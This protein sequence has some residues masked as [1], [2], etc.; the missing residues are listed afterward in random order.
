MI[1][2]KNPLRRT[3]PKGGGAARIILCAALAACFLAACRTRPSIAPDEDVHPPD[4][5]EYIPA[6]R[7]FDHRPYE[8]I[9]AERRLDKDQTSDFE[10]LLGWTVRT[11]EGVQ[12]AFGRSQDTQLWD[13]YVGAVLY[14]TAH[15]GGWAVLVPPEP[16]QIRDPVDTATLWLYGAKELSDGKSGPTVA[17]LLE[18]VSGDEEQLE[19]GVID[20]QGWRK[21]YRRLP[22]KWTDPALYPIALKSIH[23]DAL[24]PAKDRTI[25]MD[26][27]CL[28]METL[29]HLRYPVRP[30]RPLTL[31][32]GQLIGINTGEGALHFPTNEWTVIPPPGMEEGRLAIERREDG[33]Y[34]LALRNDQ[35]GP[36]YRVDVS[37][38]VSLVQ[39]MHNEQEIET[40][41]PAIQLSGMEHKAPSPVVLRPDSSHLYVEYDRG[42]VYRL[43]MRGH[44]LIVDVSYRGR[45][46]TGVTWRGPVI[47][48]DMQ[49]LRFPFLHE[50]AYAVPP[51]ILWRARA[52]PLFMH[53]QVDPYR[54]NASA[55]FLEESDT[56]DSGIWRIGA[57]YEPTTT[58]RRND[59]HERFLITVAPTVDQVLPVT[60]HPPA[61]Y[62]DRLVSRVLAVPLNETADYDEESRMADRLRQ[63]GVRDVLYRLPV[64]IWRHADDSHSFRLRAN[65]HR[66]GNATLQTFIAEQQA[67]GWA[68][69]LYAHYRAL[70]PLNA[71]W[72]PDAITRTPSREWVVSDIS[73]S[74]AVKPLFA[75]TWATE[76]T[77]VLADT[78]GA[79]AT[80]VDRHTD[81]PPWHFTDYD[82]RAP[83]AATFSQVYYADGDLMR[84]IGRQT[85]GPVLAQARGASLYAGLADGFV[86]DYALTKRPYVPCYKLN[87]L[88]SLSVM[89]GAGEPD[90]IRTDREL[91]TYLA[92]QIVYGQG[93]RLV[94]VPERP[95]LT[96]RSYYAMQALQQRYLLR[97]PKRLMYWAGNTYV[98]RDEAFTTGAW[99]RSQ[100]YFEYPKDMELWVNGSETDEWTVQ[101]RAEQYVLPPT[102]WLAVAPDFQAFSGRHD[103]RRMDY[104][105]SEHYLYLD[106]RG[107]ETA[108]G[109]LKGA[110][111]VVVYAHKD[112]E[113]EV[114][115]IM[116]TGRVGMH[117]RYPIEWE[118]MAV[119]CY[120][121]DGHALGAGAV[122]HDDP[123][124]MIS[125]PEGTMRFRLHQE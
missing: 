39:V 120:D 12:A 89:F 88:Q 49:T 53:M 47:R 9:W 79:A 2:R 31:R 70:S 101:V 27:L 122:I 64:Q 41:L 111:P 121:A 62:A 119:K 113:I 82:Q 22:S 108:Y 59:I 78:F 94:H 35:K 66:G 112:G 37:A 15:E 65:P 103:G 104:V 68:M 80:H 40:A 6:Y 77:T 96:V 10:R 102:G 124:R 23:L 3:G 1:K 52:A 67:A 14:T 51:V 57:R 109:M 125:G 55:L 54:S 73:S 58:G 87:R 84:E 83:G 60:A 48:D 69:A 110:G 81:R 46:G 117:K 97:A 18:S 114:L 42:D 45:A 44:T 36:V 16:I 85:E 90:K 28:C 25:Y 95:D 8:F 38:G 93:G 56:D 11:S 100:F 63:W 98:N 30:R 17:L 123:W 75:L 71:F 76:H 116:A 105:E 26:G 7:P 29:P 50:Q 61:P 74:Y 24:P 33:T 21:V 13:D 99:K 43:S 107:T 19:L 32:E 86:V 118:R 5:A 34:D 106:P 72:S 4:V 91:D 20:W 115:D 92:T